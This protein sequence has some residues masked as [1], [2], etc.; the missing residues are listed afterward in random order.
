MSGAFTLSTDPPTPELERELVTRIAVARR[1]RDELN[2][3]GLTSERR[4]LLQHLTR[5]GEA[6]RE[7]LVTRNDKLVHAIVHRSITPRHALTF[8]DL[9][10]EGRRGLLRATASFDPERGYRFTTYATPWVQ[11][12]VLEALERDSLIR[13]PGEAQ[14]DTRMVRAASIALGSNDP[15]LIA[16]HIAQDWTSER[17]ARALAPPRVTSLQPA[18]SANRDDQ[19]DL[20]DTLTNHAAT[21]PAERAE[22]IEARAQL[23]HALGTLDERSAY[24][25][26]AR[27]GFGEDHLSRSDV[28]SAL[29]VTAERVRQIEVASLKRLAD[30]ITPH[31]HH[32]E[33]ALAP[34]PSVTEDRAARDAELAR[35]TA[36]A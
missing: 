21:D 1:A 15:N 20:I 35:S 28:A 2:A 23:E 18:R 16:Q 13:V 9:V 25:L 29:G 12:F 7:E 19:A 24:V 4:E 17:L 36:S 10:Q 6:A 32:N 22:E 11:R 26:R 34:L 33:P 30:L 8:D 5:C 31:Q 3:G 14:H 27:F